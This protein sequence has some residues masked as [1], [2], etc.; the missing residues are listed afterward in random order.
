M[1]KGAKKRIKKRKTDF[2]KFFIKY[3][4]RLAWGT[5][6]AGFLIDIITLNR[7]D[8]LFGNM[9]L[10]FYLVL[11]IFSIILSNWGDYKDIKNKFLFWLYLYSPLIT[12]FSFGALFSGF[13]VYYTT[14]GSLAE[15]WPFLLVLYL[16][17]V[18]NE[19]VQKQ[20]EKFEFQIAVFFLSFLSFSIFFVPIIAKKVGDDI[21]I[22]SGALAIFFTFWIVRFIFKILP[23]LK[24]KK[25]KIIINIFVVYLV[26]N[27]AYFFQ[28][29]PPVPLSVKKIEVAYHVEKKHQ[30]DSIVYAIENEIWS[31][32]NWYEQWNNTFYKRSGHKIY[33]FVSV[34]APRGLRTEVIHHWEFFDTNKKEWITVQKIPYNIIG[35]R[36]SGYRSFSNLSE[37]KNGEWRVSVESSSGFLMGREKFQVING[38]RFLKLETKILKN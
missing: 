9:V 18:I 21:F 8:A 5:F 10:A 27:T 19:K 2:E 6:L 12:Q 17:F 3:K 38:E 1:F 23:I 15:S 35:G 14:S 33:V 36:D 4:G 30:E 7:I 24:R 20:Y 16:I 34:Y 26:F 22:A 31:I 32:D 28:V 29:I 13:V 11:A 37:A 25:T